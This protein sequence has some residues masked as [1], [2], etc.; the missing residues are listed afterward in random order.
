MT[1]PTPFLMNYCQTIQ[2]LASIVLLAKIIAII[3]RP[4]LTPLRKLPGPW[5]A[6]WT[7]YWFKWNVVSGK[8]AQYI[9]SLH[10]TY[11]HCVRI[12][13]N[14]VSFSDVNSHRTLHS[15]GSQFLRTEWYK[16]FTNSEGKHDSPGLFAMTDP[17]EHGNRKR[18]FSQQLSNSSIMSKETLIRAKITMA[19]DK[20]SRDAHVN[21][22]ADIMKWWTF[23]ATDVIAEL[24]F[25]ESFGLLETG[26]KTGYVRDLET[27]MM[28]TGIQSE[29]MPAF[30]LIQYLLI[31]KLQVALGTRSRL[32]EYGL[33]AIQNHREFIMKNPEASNCLFSRFL[34][35]TKN[36]Q[37]LSDYQLA[38]EAGNLIVAGSDTTSVRLTFLMEVR[39]KLMDEIS[40]VPIEAPA[41]DIM[42]LRYLKKVI[43]ESLRIYGGGPS[44]PR[45]VPSS[46]AILAGFNPDRWDA[47]TPE[48]KDAYSPFLTGPRTCL[49]MHL[50]IFEITCGIFHFLKKC[51][52]ALIAESTT[53]ESMEFENYFIMVPKGHA[54]YPRLD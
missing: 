43:E 7:H 41:K 46:G 32:N 2:L 53:D 47:P 13:P 51:P 52:T 36:K 49:G 14:E 11:G 27:T 30:N 34:D 21:G 26:E 22:F 39:D 17:R 50:A 8:R 42:I 18:L 28:I 45:M 20:F 23:L 33:V 5:Y 31:K 3:K 44:L 19:V 12:S 15:I 1:P 38:Q 6:K 54:L 48:T 25:G 29:T 35:P 4:Y 10:Q 40:S 37:E 24:S 16:T 9:D